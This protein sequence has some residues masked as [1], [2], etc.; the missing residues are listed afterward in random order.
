MQAIDAVVGEVALEFGGEDPLRPVM[1][2]LVDKTRG[3]L[4]EL[5]ELLSVGEALELPEPDAEALRLARGYLEK[6]F[7]L[8]AS[9]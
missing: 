8:M 4:K 2:S 7:R 9:L 1:R 3:R 6:G 5:H